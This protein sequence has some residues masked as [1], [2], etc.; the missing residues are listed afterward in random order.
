M[1]L[2]DNLMALIPKE[3]LSGLL[4]PHAFSLVSGEVTTSMPR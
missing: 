4:R 1:H 2:L 3:G